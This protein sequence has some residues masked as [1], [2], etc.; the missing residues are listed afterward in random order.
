MKAGREAKRMMLPEAGNTG[1][2]ALS[3]NEDLQ[4]LLNVRDGCAANNHYWLDLAAVTAVAEAEF[5]VRV[6]DTQTGRIWAYFHPAG[7]APAPL[8][9]VEAFATCP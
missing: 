1:L 8:R 3:S 9:D 6:R 7:S 4:L 2:F 5:T